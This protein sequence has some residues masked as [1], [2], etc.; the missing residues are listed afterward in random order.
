MMS[1]SLGLTDTVFLFKFLFSFCSTWYFSFP[2]YSYFYSQSA[3]GCHVVKSDKPALHSSFLYRTSVLRL[4]VFI[5][6][7]LNVPLMSQLCLNTHHRWHFLIAHAWSLSS[8]SDCSEVTMTS[9]HAE[10][11]SVDSDCS[12]QLFLTTN[13]L[14]SILGVHTLTVTQTKCSCN[15]TPSF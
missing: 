12:K 14:L 11:S 7:H 13:L 15:F 10:R 9:F 6:W 5:P 1:V 2:P 8:F 3:T 4:F